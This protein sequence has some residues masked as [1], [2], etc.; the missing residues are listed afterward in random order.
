MIPMTTDEERRIGRLLRDLN[1]VRQGPCADS[2]QTELVYDFVQEWAAPH[3]RS[4][5]RL[6]AAERVV[7]KAR[8]LRYLGETGAHPNTHLSA[9]DEEYLEL[10]AAISA[11]DE[12]VGK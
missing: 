12:V 6:A 3:V 2:D 7:E 11:Y 4:A 10:D 5:A 9:M 8:A 1:R